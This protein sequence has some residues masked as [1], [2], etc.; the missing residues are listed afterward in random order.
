MKT[1]EFIISG[2]IDAIV[3]AEEETAVNLAKEAIVIG[4]DPET[5]IMEGLSK[6]MEKVSE[7]FDNYEYFVP[8]VIVCADTMYAALEILKSKN[9]V[10]ENS[11]GKIVIGVVE[12]DTHDIG[13]NL[14][15]IMLE[16]AGF[17]IYDL[18]QDVPSNKFIDK[19]IEV[20]ADIVALSSL[21]TTTRDEMKIVIDKLNESN[22]KDKPLVMVGGGPI[23][24]L[25]AT[26]IGADGYSANAP[27]AIRLAEKLMKIREN[28]NIK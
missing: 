13:K 9:T 4:M 3:N 15:A 28:G 8:E 18:G 20:E 2:L 22:M 12:G 5:V 24:S 23:S 7:L 16:G 6:G 21:M 10:M 11:K 1:N 26:R 19:A 17:T 27:G 25:F 14:V